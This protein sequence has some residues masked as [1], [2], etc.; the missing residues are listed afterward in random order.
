[1]S[2]LIESQAR[3]STIPYIDSKTQHN[4]KHFL[5]FYDHNVIDRNN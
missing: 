5:E 4:V 2:L 3:L 1:M